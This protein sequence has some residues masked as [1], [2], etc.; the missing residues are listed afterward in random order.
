MKVEKTRQ[1]ILRLD[2]FDCETLGFILNAAQVTLAKKPEL[3]MGEE[4]KRE[5]HDEFIRKLFDAIN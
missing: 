2:N 1:V 4:Y 3:I 5:V